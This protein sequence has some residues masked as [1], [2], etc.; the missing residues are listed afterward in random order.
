MIPL[1]TQIPSKLYVACSGG[2]DS[3]FALNFVL[4]GRRNVKVLFF[5]HGTDCSKYSLELVQ[6][7]CFEKK[8][9]LIIGELSNI[10]PT[11]NL[12]SFWRKERHAFFKK[13]SD[14]PILTAHTLCDAMEWYIITAL[15][16]APKLITPVNGNIIRPFLY[17]RKSDIV[18]YLQKH[19]IP[20]FI[21]P[22]NHDIKFARA[23]LREGT[24]ANLLKINPGFDS[25]IRR[26]IEQS[27]KE[28]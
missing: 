4:N 25:V 13:Y 12:E 20:Y 2:P 14:M 18:E 15:N 10:T 23:K 28:K 24:M 5:N 7:Y 22:A 3:M 17:R 6:E 21:D 8:L 27:Q 26:L 1:A 19:K 9:E 16:G 11:S